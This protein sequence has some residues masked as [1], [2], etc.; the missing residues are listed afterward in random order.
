MP[1]YRFDI[2]VIRACE[3]IKIYSNADLIIVVFL[4]IHWLL[5]AERAYLTLEG[6]SN[7]DVRNISP[8]AGCLR[9]S[10]LLSHSYDFT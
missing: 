3:K 1:S 6:A 2:G 4:I 10:A 5:I 7:Q 8:Q 9:Y